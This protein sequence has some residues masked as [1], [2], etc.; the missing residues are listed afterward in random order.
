MKVEVW[1]Q[2][3]NQPVKFPNAKATYQKGDLLCVGYEDEFGPHVKKYP[4]QHIFCVHEEE[5]S[6]SQP[7]K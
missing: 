3:S 2:Q 4:L 1:F 7:P 6:S 5:F